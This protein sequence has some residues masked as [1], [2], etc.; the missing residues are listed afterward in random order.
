LKT[1]RV[2]TLKLTSKSRLAAVVHQQLKEIVGTI[3]NVGNCSP[4]HNACAY[5]QRE[6]KT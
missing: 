6:G 3:D 4:N 2:S 1:M 5:Y